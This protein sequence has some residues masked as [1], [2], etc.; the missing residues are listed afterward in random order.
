M[1]EHLT[2]EQIESIRSRVGAVGVVEYDGHQLVFARPSRDQVR[3]FR[4]K[5][6]TAA[7]KFDAA[8]QLSQQIL[9]AY[10][11]ETDPVKSRVAFGVFL[12]ERPMFTSSAKF[13]IVFNLLTGRVEQED[14]ADMG[15]GVRILLSRPPR[16]QP[17]SLTGSAASFA[18]TLS[19]TTAS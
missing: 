8:D 17:G 4:R 7:E 6:D 11:G 13:R 9:C 12:T 14:I 16:T 15:K 2:E 18:E 3:D 5:E 10:D 19:P 1:V